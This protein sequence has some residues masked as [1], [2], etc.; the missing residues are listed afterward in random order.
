MRDTVW[1]I[2]LT[3]TPIAIAC[4]WAAWELRG[5]RGALNRIAAAA[6]K[7]RESASKE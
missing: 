5:I 1:S 2:V 3:Q 6:E 4:L 7:L